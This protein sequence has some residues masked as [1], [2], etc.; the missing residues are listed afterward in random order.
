MSLS[1]LPLQLHLCL[2]LVAVTS[3]LFSITKAD[4]PPFPPSYADSYDNGTYGRIPLETFHTTSRSSYHLLRRTWDE[5]RCGGAEDKIF[6][7]I[8]GKRLAHTGPVIYDNDGHMV[9]YADKEEDKNRTKTTYNFRAQW[10]RGEQYLT[11][12]SGVD[13]GG[14][15]SG[16]YYMV[17]RTNKSMCEVT[18]ST[19]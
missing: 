2:I 10:Y 18:M 6:L 9:W 19:Y 16:F 15:G 1:C 11:W 8:R 12:W 3:S 14:H 7:G 4:L 5:E 13:E 17:C